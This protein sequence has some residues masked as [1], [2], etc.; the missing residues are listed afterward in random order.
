[1]SHKSICEILADLQP[2]TPVSEIVVDGSTESVNT[3][4]VLDQKTNLA[5]FLEVGGGLV[6]VDCRRIS[7]IVFP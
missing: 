3:F 1:M 2:Q 7:L 5:Y 6:I 4:I